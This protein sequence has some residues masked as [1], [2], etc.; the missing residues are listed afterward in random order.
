MNAYTRPSLSAFKATSRQRTVAGAVALVLTILVGALLP[1]ASQPWPVETNFL[2][3]FITFVALTDLLTAFL[4][5]RDAWSSGSIA[6]T[7]LAGGYLYT[8]LIV[9]PHILTFPGIFSPTGLLGA[10]PQSA[11]WFWVAWHAGFPVFVLAYAIIDRRA[12]TLPASLFRRFFAVAFASAFALVALVTATILRV[13]AGLPS[14]LVHGDYHRIIFYGIGPFVLVL[15]AVALYLLR[16]MF[17]R[18]VASL[19]VGIACFAMLL[20]IALTVTAGT[21]YSAGWYVARLNSIVASSVVLG[22]LLYEAGRLTAT[23]FEARTR[24]QTVVDG[25]ADALLSVDA[26]S[27]IVDVNPAACELFR[28]PPEALIGLPTSAL[29]P[30]YEQAA[31]LAGSDT[32]EVRAQTAD[33]TIPL[34]VSVGN[35]VLIARDITARKRAEDAT[36]AALD[37]AIS[38]ADVKARILATMSHEIRTPVNAIVG[39]SEMI[40][41]DG[42][43]GEALSHA[44]TLRAAADTLLTVINGVLD[45]SKIEAGKLEFEAIPFEPLAMLEDTIAILA[46]LAVQKGLT[47]RLD[48]DPSLPRW[49]IGDPHRIRQI[50]TNLI[51]NAIKFTQTGS[52]TVIARPVGPGLDPVVVRY[53]VSDTGIGIDREAAGRLF[54]PFTQADASTQRRFG[55]TGLGLSISKRLAELMHG[56]IGFTSSPGEGSTFWF[57]LPHALAGDEPESEMNAVVLPPGLRVLIVDDNP[58]NRMLAVRQLAKL[59]CDSHAAEGGAQALA[60]LERSPFDV[61]LMDCVM[62]EMDGFETARA[63][64]AAEAVRAQPRTPIV[65]MTASIFEQDQ[66]ALA[67]AGMDGYLSKPVTLERLRAALAQHTATKSTTS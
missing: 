42:V 62:P 15:A 29:L 66:N 24:L 13:G 56:T 43:R 2:P 35:G 59:G 53:A 27:R 38:T 21:R 22:A 41:E 63:I 45:F 65:A 28:R 47:L 61:V 58:V 30:G 11:V 52:V 10:T 55:G 64:R 51:S 39:L 19:W 48:V 40:V 33:G 23:I 36:R 20:D 54:T 3:C 46:T 31:R 60:A 16:F 1:F 37:S 18:T 57:E 25:V 8:G 4:L 6:L 32:F 26:D 14:L 50:M 12:P 67:D 49:L 34:E 7:V 9:I 5:Y 17:A 44:H